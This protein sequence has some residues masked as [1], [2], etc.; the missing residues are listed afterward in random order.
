MSNTISEAFHY[1]NPW[2]QVVDK[3]NDEAKTR[4]YQL[5]AR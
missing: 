2:H 3:E 1:L 4:Y 5:K